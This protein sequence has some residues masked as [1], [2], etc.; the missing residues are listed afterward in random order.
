MIGVRMR[1]HLEAL[2]SRF[3]GLLAECEIRE[4]SDTDDAFRLFVPKSIWEQVLGQLAA[5]IEYDKSRT[6]SPSFKGQ[7]ERHMSI[8][9]TR[10][11][12][13]TGRLR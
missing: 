5:G 3:S 12:R 6:K 7:Q 1:S 2:K 9:C 4:F 11:V 10:S 13:S 8:P